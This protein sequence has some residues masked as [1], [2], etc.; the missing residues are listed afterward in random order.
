M[1]SHRNSDCHVNEGKVVCVTTPICYINSQSRP[2][3]GRVPKVKTTTSV[4]NDPATFVPDKWRRHKGGGRCTFTSRHAINVA[5][6]QHVCPVV[7]FG[8]VDSSCSLG[9][10]HN[11]R[12]PWPD[13][14]CTKQ[15]HDSML[16]ACKVTQWSCHHKIVLSNGTIQNPR[17]AACESRLHHTFIQ[18]KTGLVCVT[19]RNSEN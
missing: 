4:F 1:P 10:R 2:S 18:W 8:S 19:S 14:L 16:S 12:C 9:S 15:V 3:Q 6:R 11:I 17:K 5:S 7:R 13:D